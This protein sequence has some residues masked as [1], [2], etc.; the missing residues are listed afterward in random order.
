MYARYTKNRQI[1]L[2]FNLENYAEVGVA[3]TFFFAGNKATPFTGEIKEKMEAMVESLKRDVVEK[4]AR[5][6]EAKNFS[7]CIRCG[8]EIDLRKPGW[9]SGT[10]GFH[11][12]FRCPP[13]KPDPP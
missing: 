8:R 2:I 5:D 12:H 11:Y 1:V 6:T 7:L 3:F 10:D 4:V 9:G 13:R